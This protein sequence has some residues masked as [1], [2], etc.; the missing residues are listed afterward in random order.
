MKKLLKKGKNAY[1]IFE[2][3]LRLENRMPT[4]KE[5]DIEFYGRAL[6]HNESNYYYYVK[7]RYLAERDG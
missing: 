4:K 7:R 6:D 3:Y 5:F 2:D 1:S